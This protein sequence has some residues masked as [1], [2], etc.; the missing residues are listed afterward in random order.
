MATESELMAL[1]KELRG[2]LPFVRLKAAERLI[3]IGEPAVPG[4]IASLDEN[5]L[6]NVQYVAIEALGRIRT[7]EAIEAIEQWRMRH[8]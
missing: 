8:L 5:H 2:S 3:E 1:L 4:L 6:P 7:P